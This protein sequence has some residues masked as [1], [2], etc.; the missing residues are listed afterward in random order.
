MKK[1]IKFVEKVIGNFW[2]QLLILI[3]FAIAILAIGGTFDSKENAQEKTLE[4][5]AGTDMLSIFL[6]AAISLIVARVA[7]RIKHTMEES[8]KLEDDHHK[9]ISKYYKHISPADHTENAYTPC[10][11]F[12]QLRCVPATRH[13]PHN[14]VEDSYSDEYPRR[15][16][17]I[18]DYTDY[19]RLYISGVNI[20]ANIKGDTDIVF[21][22]KTDMFE[23][24]PF[25]METCPPCSER[26]AAPQYATPSRCA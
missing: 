12:M 25:V 14:M 10:G 1:F 16:K 7:I 22:D 13:R 3:G 24:P 21:S 9:I 4:L 23:L 17:D 20:F 18:N 5:V 2:L 11:E 15:T 6:A 8:L 26:T 19:G